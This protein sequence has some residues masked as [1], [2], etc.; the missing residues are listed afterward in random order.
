MVLT[1]LLKVSHSFI[2]ANAIKMLCVNTE[3]LMSD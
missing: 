2:L 1:M 3:L